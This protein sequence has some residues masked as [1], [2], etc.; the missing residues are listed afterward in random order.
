MRQIVTLENLSSPS[1][2][3]NTPPP[4]IAALLFEI[5]VFSI[6]ALPSAL[7][8]KPPPSPPSSRSPPSSSPGMRATLPMIADW[9]MI[10]SA[11]GA[12]PKPPP[13]SAVLRRIVESMTRNSSLDE[14]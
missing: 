13:S 10:R 8:Q 5:V 11:S 7:L 12:L 9:R 2:S 4:P 1:A 3:W 6:S 14:L